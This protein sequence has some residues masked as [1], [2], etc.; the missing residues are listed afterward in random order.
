MT[1][2]DEVGVRFHYPFAIALFLGVA[3]IFGN[4]GSKDALPSVAKAQAEEVTLTQLFSEPKKYDG[5]LVRVIGMCSIAV[6]VSGLSRPEDGPNVLARHP[7]KFSAC[8]IITHLAD[9]DFHQK[10]EH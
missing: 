8:S 1:I 10:S 2:D 6:E 9:F 7:R 5:A 4:C 3:V